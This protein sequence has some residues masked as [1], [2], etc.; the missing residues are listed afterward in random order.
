LQEVPDTVHVTVERVNRDAPLQLR[1]LC[2]LTAY[3]PD[4]FQPCSDALY[5]ALAY[6][7][8]KD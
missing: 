6:S 7:K 2:S 8:N 1:L 5:E 3:W 4:S